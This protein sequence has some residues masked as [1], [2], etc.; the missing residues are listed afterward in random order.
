[1]QQKDTELQVLWDINRF[2]T[3][4][5]YRLPRTLLNYKFKLEQTEHMVKIHIVVLLQI[6]DYI[7][8]KEDQMYPNVGSLTVEKSTK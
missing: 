2:D 6:E 7:L 4:R 3:V 8:S 5:L 1:M